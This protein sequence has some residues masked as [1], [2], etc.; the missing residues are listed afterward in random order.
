WVSAIGNYVDLFEQKIADFTGS[1][2]A[3]ACVNGTAA[4][5]ISLILAGVQPKW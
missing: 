1:T 3:I 5:H 2:Y 4:L